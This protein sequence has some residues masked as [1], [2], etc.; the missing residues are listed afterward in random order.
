MQRLAW[1]T[2][3]IDMLERR[4]VA[5]A[6]PLP[7]VVDAPQTFD[8]VQVRL[9]GQLRHDKT[10]YLSSRT[11]RGKAGQHAVAPLVRSDGGGVVL[12][13]QGWVPADWRSPT[14]PGPPD[15]VIEGM[16][17]VFPE[18]GLF[19]P[20]NDADRNIWFIMNQ[21]E[22]AAAAGVGDVAPVFVTVAPGADPAAL[23]IGEIPGINLPNNHLG[24]AITWY[25]L[26][27]A[28]VLVYGAYHLRRDEE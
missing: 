9:T 5:T 13:D 6:L 10:L 24:Y 25:G 11:Y 2:G 1:K 28:L 7:A 21:A 3:L 20:D 23:P 15:M 14:D 26:A 12:V 27:F 4:A 8:F 17:R 19:T 18:P 16:A 22:M